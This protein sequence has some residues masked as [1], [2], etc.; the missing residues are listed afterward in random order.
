MRKAS[1]IPTGPPCFQSSDKKNSP[2]K[3]HRWRA[4]DP[5]SPLRAADRDLFLEQITSTES[6]VFLLRLFLMLPEMKL[7]FV[8]CN[9]LVAAHQALLFLSSCVVNELVQSDLTHGIH[10]KTM[11]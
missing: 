11:A 6:Q 2:P 8:G 7:V 5:A 4:R 3:T 10:S 9:Y 1:A